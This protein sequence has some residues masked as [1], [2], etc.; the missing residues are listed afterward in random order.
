MRIPI[1]P[2]VFFTFCLSCSKTGTTP[3]TTPPPSDRP[4]T[5]I[6][7]SHPV[8]L[9]TLN[10][11]V[12]IGRIAAG[13][14]DIWF[15][16]NT[17]GITSDNNSLFIT[18]DKGNTWQLIPNTTFPYLY[19]IQFLD[20]LNGFVQ[21]PGLLGITHDAGSSWVF[22]PIPSSNALYFQFVNLT[23]GFYGDI[24]GSS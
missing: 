16:S 11:W 4:D 24:P 14:Q 22:K 18:H 19:N 7:L 8:P 12:R 10:D 21:A 9:D 17:D 15:T 23:T 13:L 6:N 5:L 20:N 2:L 1:L 3:T